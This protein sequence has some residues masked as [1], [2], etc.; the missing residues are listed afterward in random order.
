MDVEAS[1]SLNSDCL[2]YEFNVFYGLNNHFNIQ[3][4]YKNQQEFNEHGD[5]KS[6]MVASFFLN[7]AYKPNAKFMKMLNFI[8]EKKIKHI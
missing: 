8:F 5:N 4:T 1:C 7:I 6:K 2:L 3:K